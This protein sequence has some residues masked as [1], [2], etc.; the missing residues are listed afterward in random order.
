MGFV[1]TSRL[2]CNYTSSFKT[3]GNTG[4]DYCFGAMAAVFDNLPVWPEI[5]MI[6]IML[7]YNCDVNLYST[8]IGES[9]QIHWRLHNMFCWNTNSDIIQSVIYASNKIEL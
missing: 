6:S 2:G 8:P 3:N 5:V 1:L 7:H 4:K 9:N